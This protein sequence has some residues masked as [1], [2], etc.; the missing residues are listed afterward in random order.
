MDLAAATGTD[1]VLTADHDGAIVAD[2]VAEWATRHEAPYDLDA[3][4]GP[5]GGHWQRGSGGER[6]SMD[7]IDFC[8][9]ISGRGE[10]P[11]LLSVQVPF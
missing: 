1:P 2:V 9:A 7:A 4:P 5:A 3:R 8:R 6:I 11:G 10:A